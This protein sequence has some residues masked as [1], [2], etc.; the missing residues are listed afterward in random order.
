MATD[1]DLIHFLADHRQEIQRTV[2]ELPDGV[3]TVTESDNPEVSAAIQKHVKAMARRVDQGQPIRMRDP[4]FAAIFRL[5]DQIDIAYRETEKGMRV[6][7][8]SDDPA[9]VRLIQAHARVVS[10]FVENGYRELRKN[11]PVPG[12]TGDEDV[13]SSPPYGRAAPPGRAGRGWGQGRGAGPGMGR[14]PGRGSG[15]GMGRGY[16]RGRRGG[17]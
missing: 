15:M 5:A 9:V 17:P 7:E 14:G 8:T 1:H 13:T 10:L 3:S 16:G 12:A 6:K 2:T 11:H 4:L